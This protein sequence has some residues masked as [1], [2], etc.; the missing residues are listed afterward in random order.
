MPYAPDMREVPLRFLYRFG[1]V[2]RMMLERQAAV[3]EAD[4]SVKRLQRQLAGR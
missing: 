4:A 3:R 1:M 2:R